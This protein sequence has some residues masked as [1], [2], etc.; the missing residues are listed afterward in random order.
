MTSITRIKENHLM[1]QVVRYDHFIETA[2]QV[3]AD[4]SLDIQGQTHQVLA[5]IDQLLS[6][7]GASKQ[8]LTRVQIWLADI[9]DF[10]E[11]NVAYEAWLAN[12]PKPVRACVGSDLVSG[13]YLIEVQ[14][15]AYIK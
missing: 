15:F 13:G 5:Q 11:M 10:A 9:D 3:C 8:D 2:G 14:A 7:V 12:C 4:T 6:Q 1:S